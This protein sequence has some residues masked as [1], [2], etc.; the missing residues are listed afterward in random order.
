M[1]YSILGQCLPECRYKLERTA[2][3]RHFHEGFRPGFWLPLANNMSTKRSTGLHSDTMWYDR[4][5]VARH[6][7]GNGVHWVHFLLLVSSISYVWYPKCNAN[8]H[9]V[10]VII[11]EIWI[12]LSPVLWC[13]SLRIQKE[14]GSGQSAGCA[15]AFSGCHLSY[16]VER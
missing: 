8:L 6:I 9:W 15:I 1:W 10:G 12:N 5:Y 4:E 14:P 13:F 3:Q 2:L 7:G 11:I 16:I